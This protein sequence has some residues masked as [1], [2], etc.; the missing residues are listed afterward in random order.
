MFLVK[1]IVYTRNNQSSVVRRSSVSGF[2]SLLSHISLLVTDEV[3]NVIWP[4]LQTSFG[5]VPCTFLLFCYLL[6]TFTY[7]YLTVTEWYV[8]C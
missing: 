8:M 4:K 7:P 3:T 5:K 2:D 6:F 1:Y